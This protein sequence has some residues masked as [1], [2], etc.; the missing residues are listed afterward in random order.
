MKKCSVVCFLLFLCICCKPPAEGI[1]AIID[2]YIEGWKNFYP[3]EAFNNGHR[4][5]AFRF[6]DFSDKNVRIWIDFNKR[7]K[8]KTEKIQGGLSFDDKVDA[9]QLRQR[10]DLELERWIHDEVLKNS[11]HFY[12]DQISGA[13]TYILVRHYFSLKE[14][15]IA[16]CDRLEGIRRLCRLGMEKLENGRPL[17][18]NLSVDLF[19]DLASFFKENLPE[20]AQ[21]WMDA[22]NFKKFREECFETVGCL[23]SLISHIKNTVMPKMDLPDGIGRDDYARKLRIHT[24]MNLSPEQ[25]SEIALEDFEKIKEEIRE[26]ASE[27]LKETEPDKKVPEDFNELMQEI[28]GKLEALRVDNTEDFLNLYRDLANR[29]ERFIQDNHVATL[30]LR[31]TFVVEL[32]PRQLARWGGVFCSGAFDPDAMTLFYIS[33]VPDDAPES[34]KEAFYKRY[35]IPLVNVLIAHELF[36]GHYLQGKYA[37]I[38]SRIVRSVFAGE[39]YIEGW[40]TLSQKV[41]LDA[42]WAESDKLVLLANLRSMLRSIASAIYSVKVHCEGWDIERTAAF[43]DKYGIDSPKNSQFLRYRVMNVPFFTLA[44]FLGYRVL[45][46]QYSAEKAR[47]G[48]AF[49]LQEFMDKLLEAGAVPM[50]AIPEILKR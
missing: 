19:E 35:N 9:D 39:L 27:Y 23:N 24:M 26:V 42:G 46:E 4:P 7:V 43:A 36:P 8:N 41:I 11:S 1:S 18:T 44:Y 14:K 22:E 6:E 3:T 21:T 49:V 2:E 5:S 29:A 12:Y 28:N 45:E 50:Y 37:A 17:S 48:D 25:L 30:P 16:V 15:R 10:I 20:I 40:A 31:R 33:W 32:S 47:L 38:N 34:D 13:L